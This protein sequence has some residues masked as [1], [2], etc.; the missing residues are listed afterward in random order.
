[1]QIIVALE[2]LALE[3]SLVDQ[4]TAITPQ[5]LAAANEFTDAEALAEEASSPGDDFHELLLSCC[6]NARLLEKLTSHKVALRCFERFF[7]GAH[8]RVDRVVAEHLAI[9][10]ALVDGNISAAD[11]ALA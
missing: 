8:D 7:V 2:S 11:S 1:M 10:H 6:P 9:A 5:V 4:L 3:L